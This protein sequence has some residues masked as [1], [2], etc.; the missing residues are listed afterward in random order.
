MVNVQTV[1]A[2]VVVGVKNVDCVL[3]VLEVEQ[4]L[5]NVYIAMVWD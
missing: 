5:K 1:L 3:I 2:W 4:Y